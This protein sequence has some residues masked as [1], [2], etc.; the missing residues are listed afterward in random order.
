MFR[1]QRVGPPASRA[2]VLLTAVLLA[3]GLLVPGGQARAAAT[4]TVTNTNDSG[5]GSLRQAILGA[6]ATPGADAIRFAIP[7]S[8]VKIISPA[9]TLPTIT[10]AVTV[11]GYTQRPCSSN[12]AP[13]SR[14]NTLAQGTNAKLLVVLDLASAGGLEIEAD[15]AVVRGS[16]STTPG[17]AASASDPVR[18]TGSRATSSAPTPP[19]L[20]PGAT[21][22]SVPR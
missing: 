10:E 2:L 15:N 4:F 20:L 13:C 18:A 11:D 7:G 3:L 19:V 9:S 17:E 21:S 22:P 12:P 8:G 6:N 16:L 1:A 5:A 14:P